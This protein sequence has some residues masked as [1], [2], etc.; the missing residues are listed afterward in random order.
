MGF[1]SVTGKI[2]KGVATALDAQANKLQAIKMR[3]ESKDSAELKRMIKSEGFFSSASDC[4]KS[5]AMKIL[6]ERGDI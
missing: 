1:W 6:R 5:M 4:E 3:L 2:V